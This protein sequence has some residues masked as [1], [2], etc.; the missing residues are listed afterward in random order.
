[1]DPKTMR[2][3]FFHG[4]TENVAAFAFSGRVI[5]AFFDQ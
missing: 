1:M 2:Q 5:L 3:F 4:H